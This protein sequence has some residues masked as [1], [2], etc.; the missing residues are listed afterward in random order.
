MINFFIKNAI[1]QAAIKLAK[2]KSLRSKVVK[3]VNNANE[4]NKKGEL[5]KTLGK[6][7]GRL[8]SK[9]YK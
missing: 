8:K 6:S 9:L 2:D 7:A 1:R 4:L 5:L 3:V